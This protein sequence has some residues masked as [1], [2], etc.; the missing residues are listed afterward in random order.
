VHHE[1]QAHLAL[2]LAPGARRVAYVG[3]ATGISAGAALVHPIEE[4]VLVELVPGVARAAARFFG[5]ANRGVYADP[6]TRVVLDDARNFLRATRRRF[7]LVIADLFVPWHAG[8]GSLYT[9]E[10]FTAVR[11]RLAPDGVFCQWLAL[12]QLS[13][14]ELDAIA[15]SFA[16][17]FPRAAVFRGDFYG[18]FPI[19]ALVG[20]AGEPPAPEAVAAAARRLAEA[21]EEDRWVTVAEGA[22]ALYVGP[23][24]PY[25]ASAPRNRDDRPWVERLA[26]AGHAG[27]Q[28]GKLDPIVGPRWVG[29]AGRLRERALRGGDPLWA[30]PEAAR[31]A[32][33]GGARLQ[34]AGALWVTGRAEAAAQAFAQ[35]AAL[36][37]P[38]LVA[39]AP[40]DPTAAEL[41][42]AAGYPRPP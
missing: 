10:H 1:R 37:P 31:R 39:A 18:R 6:R 21:G 12:Y 20:F 27:G 13:E 32:S 29:W 33:A 40:E 25:E 17:V 28:R 9:R 34:E 42:G 30:L 8:A 4:L 14:R 15:A 35:A 2:L 7:D 11:E 38:Q 16:D 23:L 5:D 24:A 3:S 22:F 26:A 41:W 36:L 19:A